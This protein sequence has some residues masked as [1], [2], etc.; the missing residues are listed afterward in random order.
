MPWPTARPSPSP[1]RTAACSPG[2]PA[3]EA[4]P[5]PPPASGRRAH[6]RRRQ[7]A[8]HFGE[9]AAVDV[10]EVAEHVH[11]AGRAR[12]RAQEGGVAP[13]RR[14]VVLDADVAALVEAGDV[15]ALL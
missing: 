12:V 1:S 11:V 8:H 6:L 3:A 5:A 10:V 9:R 15:A 14:L 7:V 13:Q 2:G 4:R